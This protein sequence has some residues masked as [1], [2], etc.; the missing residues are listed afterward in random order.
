M[1][2][3]PRGP[4]GPGARMARVGL[5]A[6]FGLVLG[7]AVAAGTGTMQGSVWPAAVAAAGAVTG[8][9]LNRWPR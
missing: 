2:L 9:V 1:P 6:T 7:T 8:V 5:G 4:E 3:R